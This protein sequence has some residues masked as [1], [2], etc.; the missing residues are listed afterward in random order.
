M[1]FF[2]K[3]SYG[4]YVVHVPIVLFLRDAGLSATD[5]PRLLGSTLPGVIVF[6]AVGG[7]LSVAC[8]V[9]VYHVWEEP[10]LRLKRYLPYRAAPSGARPAMSS[11]D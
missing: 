11:A 1:V 8:A 9:V 4:L 10:F 6:S 5:F 3:Y 7:L 2:G